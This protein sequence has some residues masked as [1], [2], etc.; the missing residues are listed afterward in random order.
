MSDFVENSN[1]FLVVSTLFGPWLTTGLFFH[2]IYLNHIGD[3]RRCQIKGL[4]YSFER[5]NLS[6]QSPRDFES[7]LDTIDPN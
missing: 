2:V 5:K 3:G 7:G 6:I 4:H 1:K